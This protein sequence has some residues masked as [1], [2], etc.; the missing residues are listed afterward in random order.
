MIVR[1]ITMLDIDEKR[2]TWE[3]FRNSQ[4]VVFYIAL[5]HV[6]TASRKGG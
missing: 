2:M 5:L 6:V 3:K 4:P 1:W